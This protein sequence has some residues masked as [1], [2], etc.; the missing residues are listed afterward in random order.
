[1]DEDITNILGKLNLTEGLQ[2]ISPSQVSSR[3]SGNI[4]TTAIKQ[5]STSISTKL[6]SRALA[7]GNTGIFLEFCQNMFMFTNQVLPEKSVFPS[8][9]DKE[10]VEKLLQSQ[11][12]WKEYTT[13]GGLT[14]VDENDLTQGGIKMS[15]NIVPMS[16]VQ[17]FVLGNQNSTYSSLLSI[18]MDQLSFPKNYKK[19][20]MSIINTKRKILF[21]KEIQ[22]SFHILWNQIRI[23][24]F[25][26][27]R[28]ANRKQDGSFDI[29]VITLQNIKNYK[30][31]LDSLKK[32]DFSK[33]EALH[34]NTID[35]VFK[36]E[37]DTI[38]LKTELDKLLKTFNEYIVEN[39][40]PLVEQIFQSSFVT[41]IKNFLDRV[42]TEAK[43][44]ASSEYNIFL[45]VILPSLAGSFVQELKLTEIENEPKEEQSEEFKTTFGWRK[46]NFTHSRSPNIDKTYNCG[47]FNGL[48]YQI[49][50]KPILKTAFPNV[51]Q[52]IKPEADTHLRFISSEDFKLP[53]NRHTWLP[54]LSKWEFNLS[55]LFSNLDNYTTSL[56]EFLS[57][58]LETYFSLFN[59]IGM[60][61]LLASGKAKLTFQEYNIDEMCFPKLDEDSASRVNEPTTE[62]K[63]PQII[64]VRGQKPSK[65]LNVKLDATLK[66][67][68]RTLVPSA[69]GKKFFLINQHDIIIFHNSVDLSTFDESEN[70][71]IEYDEENGTV[72]ST[73]PEHHTNSPIKIKFPK[74]LSIKKVVGQ[75]CCLAV[76][77]EFAEESLPDYLN[78][79]IQCKTGLN[80]K[81]LP[82]SNVGIIGL[83]QFDETFKMSFSESSTTYTSCT[84]GLVGQAAKTNERKESPKLT[85][86]Y[87]AMSNITHVFFSEEKIP[88][89]VEW[90]Q[91][92]NDSLGS[93]YV[94][95]DGL[96]PYEFNLSKTIPGRDIPWRMACIPLFDKNEAEE[97]KPYNILKLFGS[98]FVMVN[99]TNKIAVVQSRPRLKHEILK[100]QQQKPYNSF[101]RKIF[102]LPMPEP[103]KITETGTTDIFLE[104]PRI[105]DVAL[106]GSILAVGFSDG[107]V[108]MIDLYE[109]TGTCTVIIHKFF[110]KN[111]LNYKQ[112]FCGKMAKLAFTNPECLEFFT[113]T[114]NVLSFFLIKASKKKE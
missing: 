28:V 63:E 17:E 58:K 86:S 38:T 61:K 33:I 88:N 12:Y 49:I 27:Y 29:P 94:V 113:D 81:H 11:F 76:W 48:I 23:A 66:T 80:A 35:F 52:Y 44:W 21:I 54:C 82:L 107:R 87:F 57:K 41:E 97:F 79:Y 70:F 84:L 74:Y 32:N 31:F 55:F 109:N 102:T 99:G 22:K 64:K 8:K 112:I 67:N 10:L 83:F 36:N 65:V 25:K 72:K 51:K 19:W 39:C 7:Q 105:V 90:N 30:A 92:F 75:N 20:Q 111:P 110:M 50:F 53:I 71:I 85:G 96:L 104:A 95:Q 15:H 34:K 6:I 114:G 77:L 98:T 37:K 103:L 3:E 40:R 106:L 26:F 16:E 60:N 9:L 108:A 56:N 14:M 2:D 18:T 89:S 73:V 68:M 47:S 100:L 78:S 93:L 101:G 43:H 13:N 1:M 4:L 59:D 62:K 24:W 69:D 45:W 46:K 42:T 91:E 5:G